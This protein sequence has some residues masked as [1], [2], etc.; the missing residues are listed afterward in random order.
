M[1]GLCTCSRLPSLLG[2]IITHDQYK[3]WGFWILLTWVSNGSTFWTRQ[4][5]IVNPPFLGMFEPFPY[6]PPMVYLLTC[7]GDFVRTNV[8]KYSSTTTVRIW[9]C[10]MIWGLEI[11]C[12]YTRNSCARS[13]TSCKVFIER[14]GISRSYEEVSRV[15]TNPAILP[16]YL[17]VYLIK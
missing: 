9:D 8:G 2:I 6:A 7:L 4:I 5:F 14:L 3:G 11:T 15:P 12:S 17:K 16:H 13:S 1:V 10:P